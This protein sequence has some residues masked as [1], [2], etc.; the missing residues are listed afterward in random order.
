MT[1]VIPISISSLSFDWV[2]RRGGCL[3]AQFAYN[4][5]RASL[6]SRGEGSR[7][8]HVHNIS[9]N[10]GDVT[11]AR[12]TALHGLAVAP[13]PS[14][15]RPFHFTNR[16]LVTSWHPH[17]AVSPAMLP[18]GACRRR[19]GFGASL[20]S[21]RPLRLPLHAAIARPKRFLPF[22]SCASKLSAVQPSK[23]ETLDDLLAQAEHYANY[24]MRNM[25]RMPPTLFL[26]G[27]NG[28]LMA[29]EASQARRVHRLGD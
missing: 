9:H 7:E 8:N 22:A 29:Q 28:P 26:I 13:P 6:K 24:S 27:P 19:Y 16:A 14:R 25:G 2:T 23:L 20:I 18:S 3:L 21:F 11:N 4:H 1:N 5:R 12:F 17:S 10:V 15:R